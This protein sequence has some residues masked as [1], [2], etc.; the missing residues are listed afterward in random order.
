MLKSNAFDHPLLGKYRQRAED[1]YPEGWICT[2]TVLSVARMAQLDADFVSL[3]KTFMESADE[4]IK[5]FMWLYYYLQYEGEENF[6]RNIWVLDEIPVPEETEEKF[7]GCLKS[8]VYLLA[9]FRLDRWVQEK[10]LPKEVSQAYFGRYRY[11]SSL[12]RVTHNTPALCRL[13]PFLYGYSKPFSLCLGRLAFQVLPFKDY[14]ELYEDSQGNRLFVALPNYHYDDR[15]LQAEDGWVPSYEI[16]GCTLIAHVFNG[17]GRLRL[18]PEPID[19]RCYHR[20]LSP[21]D[22]VVTIH[23]PEGGRLTPESVQESLQLAQKVFGEHFLQTKAFVCQTWFIDPNL[24]GEVVRDGS[25]MAMF[26]DLFDVICGPDNG[27]HSVFEHVFVVK[28]QP[29]ENL[30][31]KTGLQ[32]RILQYVLDGKPMYWGFGV[33]KQGFFA[34]SE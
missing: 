14:C 2:E 11:L 33:L 25:N 29:L 9:W 8:V 12:N 5:R 7:P 4:D 20:I 1:T 21:A 27:Y 30:V 17:N 6:Y 19:L 34:N 24:R 15:G 3:L 22:D 23:I 31:P 18:Q 28:K 16:A 10:G 32:E 13:S 26:A